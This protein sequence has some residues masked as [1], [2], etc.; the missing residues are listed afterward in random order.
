MKEYL[1]LLRFVKPYIG[2]LILASLCMGLSTIFDGVSLGMIVPFCDRVLSNREIVV[3]GELPSFLSSFIEKINTL[4][5]FFI[6]KAMAIGIISLYFFKGVL[7]FFQNYLMNIVGQGVVKEV[8]NKLYKKLQ[9]LSLNFYARKRTGELISRIT[10]DVNFIAHAISYALSDFLYQSMQ[11]I[12]Y[13]FL[14]FYIS[15]RWTLISLAIFPFILLSTIRVGKLVRKYSSETQR[16]MAD[17]NSQLSET[18]QGVWVVKGFSREDYEY[19]RFKKINNQYYKYILKSIKKTVLLSPLTQFLSAIGAAIILVV[20]GKD[21]IEGRFSFGVFGLFLGALLSL[22]KPLKK[23]SNVYSI[24]QQALAASER[25][26]EVLEE[27]TGIKD[28]PH[29]VFINDFKEGIVFEDVW[30]RYDRDEKLVLKNINLHIKKNDIIALVGRSGV[31]KS[32]LVKLMCRFYEPT[33]GRILIDG[34]DIRDIKI[35][36]L[37]K[38]ISIVSQDTILFNDTVKENIAYGKEKASWEEIV[39]AARKAYCYEFIMNLPQG[40]DTVVGNRGFKLSA[41]QKQ[42]IAIARAILRDAPILILDEATSQLDFEAERLIRNAI[43]NL[44]KDRTV[45]IIAHRLSTIQK[46]SKIVVLEGGEIVEQGTHFSLMAK[47]RLY[48]KLYQL[49]LNP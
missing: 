49:Q 44:I 42:R 9:E 22:V 43:H 11:A 3:P 4:D 36:S 20:G 1:K 39:E 18:I 46:S 31:G 40:F 28:R 19:E 48:K 16:R 6:L 14:V 35:F 38:L 27:E 26:Y 24:N 30:F 13:A 41:G 5:S 23:L 17:L 47:G 21:V 8:R 10:N 45:F 12:F 32:T 34:R 7:L 25:I 15:W 37:R 29:S 33:R 2:Y